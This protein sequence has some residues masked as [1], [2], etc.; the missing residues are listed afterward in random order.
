MILAPTSDARL[1]RLIGQAAL[2][3]ED[4]F[5]ETSTVLDALERGSP[6]L[7]IRVPEDPHPLAS[8]VTS[9]AG[10]VPVLAVV[11]WR[12]GLR[13]RG[14]G[15]AEIALFPVDE[16][17]ERLRQ[18]IDGTA[19]THTWTDRLLQD[20]G[21]ASGSPLA[22][23]LRGMGRRVLEFPPRYHDLHQLA[24]LSGLTRDALKARFR[25]RG[26]P[27]PFSY[28]RWFRVLAASR[29]LSDPSVTTVAA[30]FRLGFTS[31]GNLCRSVQATAG[32]NPTDLRDSGSRDRLLIAFTEEL[33]GADLEEPLGGLTD[34]FLR[35]AA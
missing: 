16:N 28:L 20:L 21:R 22:A 34:L 19:A 4:V 29:V 13:S 10:S 32:L 27:S 8:S 5:F 18:L 24:R 9:R 35:S 26:L 7:V 1:R 25:R 3:E 12:N 14:A 33:L 30:A 15:D 17:V 23:G 6:R 31:S 2:P 11:P